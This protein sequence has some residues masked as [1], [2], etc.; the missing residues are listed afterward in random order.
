[1]DNI[2]KNKISV[3]IPVLDFPETLPKILNAINDQTYKPRE[4]VIV[5]SG[6][7]Q[8]LKEFLKSNKNRIP[9]NVTYVSKAYPGRARNIGGELVKSNWIA[10]L[11]SKTL[12]NNDWLKTYLD[13]SIKKKSDV[14]LGVTKFI[15]K[16]KFQKL[17]N[18]CSY[19]E[20]FYETVPGTIIKTKV[21]KNQIPFSINYKFG[22]DRLWKEN[23][24]NSSLKSYTP[25]KHSIKYIGLPS[26]YLETVKKYYLSSL[27]TYYKADTKLEIFMST[28]LIF[29]ITLLPRWNYII[30]GWTNNH[31]FIPHVS[32][33]VTASI[34]VFYVLHIGY[35]KKYNINHD[36]ILSYL[37]KYITLISVLFI[38]LNW[39]D[40]FTNWNEDH[41][42]FFPHV[43]KLYIIV[44][45]SFS[46]V[47][48]GLI[49]PI[50]KKV[51][52]KKLIPF[53][54]LY[55]GIL[56]ASLD[57]IKLFGILHKLF[58]RLKSMIF[59]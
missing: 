16:N 3:V 56:G 58:L 51:N 57:I 29:Y 10:F 59:I 44:L 32:K 24:N 52:Y 9:L 34:L 35:R 15:S 46:I 38:A 55:V 12:P 49:I 7:H 25:K 11:D 45:I 54:W 40:T 18:Y 1:M 47:N 27:Y 23:L 42:M 14:V 50:K 2:N 53:R 4:I 17:Y 5:C 6:N 22:E 48:R 26:S 31:L 28:F 37:L 41:T 30:D 8:G 43:T 39:N 20:I 36:R 13:F 21:F 33:I 19:G